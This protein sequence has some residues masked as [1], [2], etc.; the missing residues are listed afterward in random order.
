MCFCN[1][2]LPPSGVSIG[3]IKPHCD[4]LSKRGPTT[5]AVESIGKLIFR[6]WEINVY[7]LNRFK[8]CT[9]PIR[10]VCASE[11]Q[12]PLNAF[13]NPC[14]TILSLKKV[15]KLASIRP[16]KLSL[17]LFASDPLSPFVFNCFFSFLERVSSSLYSPL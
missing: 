10:F 7:Q 3:S 17:Y 5:L 14:S 13:L 15:L 8:S 11:P 6:K 12:F 9:A 1:P 4:E 2:I 16:I